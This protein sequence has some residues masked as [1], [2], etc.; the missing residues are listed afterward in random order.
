MNAFLAI[1]ANGGRVIIVIDREAVEIN[2]YLL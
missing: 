2:Y 1:I